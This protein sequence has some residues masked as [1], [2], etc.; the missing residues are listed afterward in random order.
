VDQDVAGLPLRVLRNFRQPPQM[1]SLR[2]SKAFL[3]K[4]IGM[5][6]YKPNKGIINNAIFNI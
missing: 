6:A 1:I 4:I 2:F 5:L 3:L